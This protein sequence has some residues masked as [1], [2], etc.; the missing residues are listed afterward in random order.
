MSETVKE[1][2]VENAEQNEMT[3]EEIIARRKELIKFYK[4]ETPLLKARSEYEEHLTK[5]EEARFARFQ[6]RVAHAQM[7]APQENPE[8]AEA[9]MKEEFAKSTMEPRTLKTN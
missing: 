3:P 8:E 5:I 7:S 4:D 2:S 1:A 9:R 6:I